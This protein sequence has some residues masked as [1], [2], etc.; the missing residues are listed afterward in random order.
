MAR[1]TNRQIINRNISKG[2]SKLT[3]EN[4][5]KLEQVY[6][7]DASFG[8]VA[9]YLDVAPQTIYNWEKANPKLFEKLHRLSEKPVLKAR[10]TVI[11]K[12]GENYSD[13]MDY[14][15]RKKKSEFSTRQEVSGELNVKVEKLSEIQEATKKLLDE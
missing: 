3:P 11:Q 8:E 7:L 15:S 13:A 4:I 14:L 5:L 9:T 1:P 12:L 6:S 10:Q 2:V